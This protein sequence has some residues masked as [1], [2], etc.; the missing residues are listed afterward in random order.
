[1][2]DRLRTIALALVVWYLMLPPPSQASR[3]G[4]DTA[5]PLSTWFKAPAEYSSQRACEQD[6]VDLVKMHIQGLAKTARKIGIGE[7][8]GQCV[9]SDDPRLKP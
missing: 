8:L 9:T 2:M 5:A 1:M 4:F 6:R 7:S 3:S